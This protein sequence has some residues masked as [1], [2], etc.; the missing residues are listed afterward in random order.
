MVRTMPWLLLALPVGALTDRLDRRQTMLVANLIRAVMVVIVAAGLSNGGGSIWLLYV[1]ALG[2]GVAEVFY[3][4][5]AQSIL[6][7]LVDR[8][9]L[10]RAN[11]RLAAIEL[12]AQQFVGP[13]LAGALVAITLAAAFWV[14]AMLWAGAI[15]LLFSMRGRYRPARSVQPA[16]IRGDI[17]E[18]VRFL[19]TRPLLRAMAAMVG[20]ANLTSSASAAVL[21]LFAV[22]SESTLGLTAAQFGFLLLATAIGS[23]SATFMTDWFARH[24]GR[25]RTLTIAIFGMTIFVGAPAVTTNVAV[26][27][28]AMMIGGMMLMLWNIPTVSFRQ[29]VTPDHLLGRLNSVYRMIAWGTMPLGAL[30]GGLLAEWFGVRAVF[31]V[32]GVVTLTLLIPN[33]VITDER[34]VAAEA[35]A[36]LDRAAGAT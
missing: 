30:L 36:D 23:I 12:G 5:S 34:L 13:P 18:G 25:A 29:R 35:R 21:V 14:S 11:G 26:L 1:C 4:T 17:A 31:A 33:R 6:P 15:I 27:T 10:G 22:G 8:T 7:S 24:V 32:M 16:S 19:L 3:D 28:L 9:R 2:T 20:I